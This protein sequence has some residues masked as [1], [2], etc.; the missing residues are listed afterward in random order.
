M[1]LEWLD[2]RGDAWRL[3]VADAAS[4]LLSKYRSKWPDIVPV[5]LHRLAAS[6]GVSIQRVKT[7]EGGARLIPVSDGFCVFISDEIEYPRFRSAIAHELAHTLFYVQ[8]GPSWRRIVDQSD[9]RRRARE[10]SFCFD[11]GRRIL[12]PEWQIDAFGIRSVNDAAAILKMFRERFR[13]NSIVAARV[14]LE[15]YGLVC[16][17][18][19]YWT[20]GRDDAWQLD[21]RRFYASRHLSM[22][23]RKLLLA[24]TNKW[25]EEGAATSKSERVLPWDAFSGDATSAYECLTSGVA[26][27]IGPALAKR[28]VDTFGDETMCIL[29]TNPQRLLRVPGISSAKIASI[30][31]GFQKEFVARIAGG[32]A[33]A[34]NT[35][36]LVAE[37]PNQHL[38][39]QLTSTP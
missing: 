11:V 5:E 28:I 23:F 7:L 17:V 14:M 25:L 12:V 33:P 2:S 36:F 22:P 15:D 3:A 31:I 10:E 35:A 39:V 27:G 4:R 6:L 24:A 32:V 30:R 29:R 13:L 18:A 21:K 1:P 16:G 20:K 19:G 26:R 34:G 37:I 8:D 9:A 38:L